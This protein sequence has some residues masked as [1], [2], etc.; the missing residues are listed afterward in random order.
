MI[1]SLFQRALSVSS[2]DESEKNDVSATVENGA[3]NK[4]AK[5]IEKDKL[6]NNKEKKIETPKNKEKATVGPS[7]T[8]KDQPVASKE[9]K[10]TTVMNFLRAKRDAL[11]SSSHINKG[12]KSTSS[13]TSDDSSSS[14]SDSSESSS[15]ADPRNSEDDD[16]DRLNN[17]V[18]EN[19]AIDNAATLNVLN[20]IPV[21]GV[22]SSNNIPPESDGKF[23]DNLSSHHRDM[24]TRL[25]DLA[26]NPKEIFFQS[27]TLDLLYKYV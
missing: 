21:N 20:K 15:D 17:K 7:D 13:A 12:S 8:T 25:I 4:K 18:P 23:V 9:E 14:E 19:K 24:L 16:F 27:D 6:M 1:Y 3:I 11:K 10:T 22:S 2:E 5:I 26:K